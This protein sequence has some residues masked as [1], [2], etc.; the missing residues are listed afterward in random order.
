MTNVSLKQFLCE[1]VFRRFKTVHLD[2]IP[3]YSFKAITQE[4]LEKVV[5]P[6]KREFFVMIKPS[7]LHK[8]AEIKELIAQFHLVISREETYQNFSEIAASMFNIAKI[9]DYRH[10]LPEGYIWLT[11]LEYFYPETCQ[12]TKVL[13]IQNGSEKILRRLKKR[14]RQKI[15]VE[16]YRVQIQD[17]R[18]VTCM[19]PVHT[20]DQATLERELKILGYFKNTLGNSQ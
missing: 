20:S 9:H 15:G 10:A 11:L 7:G 12:I 16:F 17:L 3:H 19:T 1:F 8:E 4:G 5:L 18:I 14:I 13:Y 6:E 2:V